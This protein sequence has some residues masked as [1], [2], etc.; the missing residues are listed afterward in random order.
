MKRSKDTL[1]LRTFR[2]LVEAA[3]GLP[4]EPTGAHELFKDARGRGVGISELVVDV[5]DHVETHVETYKVSE[6][7]GTYRKTYP[8]LHQ[9]VY[10]LF[11]RHPLLEEPRRLDE[12]RHQEPVP[13][14]AGHVLL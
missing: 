6:L 11:A 14:E 3:P 8:L 9:Q 13:H 2:V 5:G 12:H 7:E 4:A 1:I 10:L